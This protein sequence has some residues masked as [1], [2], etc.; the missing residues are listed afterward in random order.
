VGAPLRHDG[1]RPDGH[2]ARVHGQAVRATGEDR[3]GDP[4][5]HARKIAALILRALL[6]AFVLA[7]APLAEAAFSGSILDAKA[8]AKA[9]AKGAIVWDVRSIEDYRAGHIPGAV[10]LGSLSEALLDEKTQLFLPIER[11]ASRLGAAGIDLKREIVVY[12]GAASPHPYFAEWA[13]DYFG[14]R[15]VHVFHD[16]FEGWRAAKKPTS[17]DDAPRKP[18]KVRPMASPPMLVTTGE[19]IAR[20]GRRDVQIVDTRR[21]SEYEGIEVETLKGGHIPGAIHIPVELNFREDT[22]ALL[23]MRE[24]RRLYSQLEPHKETIV[25]CHTGVRAAMTAAILTRLG[26]RSVRLYHASWREY[27]NQPDAPGELSGR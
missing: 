18:V 8:T 26:F 17:L 27:G 11:I 2:R 6:S 5:P 25:Y 13:L 22:K 9:I 3:C 4:G 10:N 23:P 16:G 20:L 24:L 1:Q 14:A 19:V 7:F 21:M 12:G 15:T